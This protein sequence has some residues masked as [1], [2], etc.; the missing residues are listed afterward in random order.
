M[1]NLDFSLDAARRLDRDDPLA[2]WRAAFH[3]PPGPDGSDCL[4]FTG[5][6]LGLQP[7]RVREMLQEELDD[8]A[9]LGVQGH[10]EAR[11][12]WMPYHENFTELNARLVGAKPHEVVQMNSLTVNLHLM[13][14]SFY[15]PTAER[16]A[17]L[18]EKPAFPSDRHAAASQIRFH[19]F[20]P[21]R[22]LIEIGP[23]EGEANI[24]PDDLM[25]LIEEEG[26]RIALVL[27]P[28]VQYYSGQVFDM[29]GI[30]RAAQAKGAKVGFDLA[31]A[32]GNIPL[33]LHD[34]GVDFAAWCSYKYLNG[35]PGAIAGCF[36]HERHAEDESL[37]RFAGWWGHDKSSRFRMG[38]EFHPIAGAEGWQ[39]SNPPI[40]SMTPV[41]ASLQIFDEV[42]MEA[43]RE[44]SLK[45][46]DTLLAWLDERLA[47]EVEVITPRNEQERGCQ[48][49]LR[50][51][52]G[53][54]RQ[55]FEALEDNGVICDWRYPDVIRIAPVPLYN[56]F[57][58]LYHFVGRLDKAIKG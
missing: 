40:L 19:G 29:A 31:H 9:R 57:E 46:S 39:L 4:Y 55:V 35:G 13:M 44:K 49:S 52:Q 10:T 28:G 8:W 26:H 27:L 3:I 56:R 37:P 23:R 12:P 33:Q 25:A 36:V 45:L 50:L 14:V 48:L 53:D 5:N 41:L 24:R 42:G 21:E 30:A 18:I 20:D 16:P 58:D 11:R 2:E 6:S 43:L 15:R 7:R 47:E 38:P 1:N 34:W 32:A 54:G 22:D 17:I 51:K